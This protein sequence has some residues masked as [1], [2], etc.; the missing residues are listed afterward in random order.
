MAAV[1]WMWAVRTMRRD[2]RRARLANDDTDLLL[3]EAAV[4]QRE[5]EVLA[6]QAEAALVKAQVIMDRHTNPTV[7][8]SDRPQ[9]EA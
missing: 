1:L 8:R 6:I 7:W 2:L 4:V 5:T 9:A 3:L